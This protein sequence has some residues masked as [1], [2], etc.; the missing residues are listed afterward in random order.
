MSL[1]IARADF[2][3]SPL[4]RVSTSRLRPIASGG[5]GVPPAST[6]A[7]HGRSMFWPETTTATRLPRKRRAL[8]HQ[9]R[10]GCG[11]R[12]FRQ[13][14]RVGVE[15]ADRLGD[16]VVGHFDQVLHA[17]LQDRERLRVGMRTAMP[18]ANVSAEL[19]GTGRPASSESR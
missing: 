6:V 13:G 18:S 8:A 5:C 14:V 12:A 4:R 2:A 17:G 3:R 16:L 7:I 9:G 1:L 19:V 15:H 11:A 10:E